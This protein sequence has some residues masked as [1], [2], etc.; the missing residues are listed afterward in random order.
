MVRRAIETR[1]GAVYG[2]QVGQVAGAGPLK[3]S[4]GI[5]GYMPRCAYNLF[6]TGLA[7]L[8]IDSG[9]GILQ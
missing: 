8:E 9:L 4:T 2:A 7:A 3:E 1:H 6:D 5:S